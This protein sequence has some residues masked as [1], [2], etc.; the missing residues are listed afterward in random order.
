MANASQ[1][2]RAHN[3]IAKGGPVGGINNSRH[4]HSN[5]NQ[6]V[7]NRKS[8]AKRGGKSIKIAG[9]SLD[10]TDQS[11]HPLNDTDE[12]SMA[13][14]MFDNQLA[15]SQSEDIDAQTDRTSRR[16][17][18]AVKKEANFDISYHLCKVDK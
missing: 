10:T 14:K 6:F 2:R 8:Q 15:Q 3:T 18:E 17:A 7:V 12:M 16:G 13:E 4:S 9:N 1:Q 11:A 5:K